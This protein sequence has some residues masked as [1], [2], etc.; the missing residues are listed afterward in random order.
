MDTDQKYLNDEFFVTL[1][2]ELPPG[3][4]DWL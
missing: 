4:I 2:G 1:A 3:E